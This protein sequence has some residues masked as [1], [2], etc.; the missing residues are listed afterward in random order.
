M[1]QIIVAL[2]FAILVASH[3]PAAEPG[4]VVALFEDDAEGLLKLLD[5]PTG[6]PG[7]GLPEKTVVFSGKESIKIIPMQRFSP[8]IKGWKH[9]IVEKPKPGE[10]RFLRFAWKADGCAGVMLQLHDDK[11]WS[12]RY[13]AGQ[14]QQGWGTKFVADSAPTNWTVTTIDLYKDFGERTLHGIALTVF[15]G[16]AGYF[17]HI[18]LARS[19]ADLDRIDATGLRKNGKPLEL[20]ER[21]MMRCWAD[22]TSDQAEKSYRAFWMLVNAGQPAARFLKAKL[23]NGESKIDAK[24]IQKWILQLNS[25]RFAVREAA[26][27][28]LAKNLDAAEEM[29]RSELER[30][31]PPE[32]RKRMLLLLGQ[33]A[34][35][36][37]KTR[38]RTA[39][40]ILAEIDRLA[41][42]KPPPG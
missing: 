18:Y 24:Q 4:N 7:Q 38:I 31:P 36:A 13:T 40:Q 9:R 32:T 34:N 6:D 19:I 33:Q 16:N 27:R 17:D 41:Q 8:D 37:E 23:P 21:R 26:S 29:L 5:N 30:N 20:S 42:I 15:G 28:E 25:N 12:I 1:R 2:A 10:Y 14:N 39:R 3:L 11:D 35:N 22:L